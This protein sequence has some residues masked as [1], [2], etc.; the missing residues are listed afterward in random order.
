MEIIVGITVT[1]ALLIL[2]FGMIWGKGMKLF[3]GRNLYTIGFENIGGLEKGD[4]VVIRGMEQG[5]VGKITMQPECV[6]V[7]I[8]VNKTLPLYS[9]FSVQIESR[10]I[11]GGKQITV[12]PGKS[13]YPADPEKIYTGRLRGDILMILSQADQILSRIDSVFT[14]LEQLVDN[15]RLNKVMAN[16]EESA[17]EARQ[18][19]KEIRPQLKSTLDNFQGVSHTLVEDSAAQ[20]LSGIINRLD[21]ASVLIH[22]VA[23]EIQTEDGTVGKMIKDRAL[24]D[25]LLQTTTHMDSLILDIKTNPKRYV[26]MSLF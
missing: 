5:E 17:S 19:F 12:I 2:I 1:M 20:K 24:F 6:I 4:P 8:S 15:D 23:G 25:Q 26:H 7:Q 3:S 10:E 11:I 14:G 9:D 13:G 16:V 18:L 21:S 22:Q